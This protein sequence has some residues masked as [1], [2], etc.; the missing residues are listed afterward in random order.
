MTQ[1]RRL[2][3]D[4]WAEAALVALGEG[5]LSAVAVEPIAARLGVTKGSFY[6]HFANRDALVVAAL[7]LW[8]Q[9]STEARITFLDAEPDPVERIRVLFGQAIELAGRDPVEMNLR[10]ASDHELVAP[11]LRQVMER[12]LWYTIDLFEAIGFSREESIQRGTIA[13]SAYVGFSELTA[14]LPGLMPMDDTHGLSEYVDSVL[15]LL[16]RDRPA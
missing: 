7:G 5:G 12:R 9:R 4:D 15:D 16:L 6:W 3:A 1:E 11:L 2:T 13:F 10:A 8:G 14:R